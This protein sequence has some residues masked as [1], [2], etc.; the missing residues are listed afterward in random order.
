MRETVI[1]MQRD[2]ER[3]DPVMHANSLLDGNENK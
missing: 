1:Q 2:E 3:D